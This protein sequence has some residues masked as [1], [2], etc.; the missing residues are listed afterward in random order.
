MNMPAA[1]TASLPTILRLCEPRAMSY[2]ASRT[3]RAMKPRKKMTAIDARISASRTFFFRCCSSAMVRSS[4]RVGTLVRVHRPGQRVQHAGGRRVQARGRLEG[5]EGRRR[6]HFPFQ[7]FGAAAV[8]VVPGALRGDCALA[9]HA[10][11]HDEDEEVDLG[12]AEE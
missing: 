6:G 1:T 8:E 10:R 12:E 11:Q 2:L 4:V 5:V 9:A 3:W 7:A